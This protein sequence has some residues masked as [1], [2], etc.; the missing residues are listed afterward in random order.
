MGPSRSRFSRDWSR[1]ASGRACTS[2]P[3]APGA[4]ITWCTRWST[5]PSMRP[6]RATATRSWWCS[7]TTAP[8]PSPTTAAASPPTSIPAPAR[9]PWRRCSPCCTPAASSAPA[10]TRCPVACTGW[11]CRW[12]TPSP[13]GWRSRFTAKTRCTPSASSVANRSASSNRPLVRRAAPAP[14]CASSRISRFSPPAS[15][16]TTRPSLLACGSW[17]TST[18]ECG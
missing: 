7:T 11:A 10:V 6:W 8:A 9:A 17:P 14:P 2:A 18:A 5:T 3:P 12:S 13:S 16:S 4:C 1:C 15:N